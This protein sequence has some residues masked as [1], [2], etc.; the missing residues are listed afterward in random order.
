MVTTESLKFCLDN[1]LLIRKHIDA[2]KA[3]ALKE[4]QKGNRIPGY[5]LVQKLGNR[6]WKEN[7][8]SLIRALLRSMGYP[9][10]EI[11]SDDLATPSKAEKVM[12]RPIA[13]TP[14]EEFVHREVKG[15]KI[16]PM[17]SGGVDL[18]EA[19]IEQQFAEAC[20]V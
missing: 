7:S 11:S 10:D 14:L 4:L 3:R 5:K 17:E 13:G 15:E 6:Q 18:N 16:V 20:N 8:A 1:E 19:S 12:K 2:C 9:V